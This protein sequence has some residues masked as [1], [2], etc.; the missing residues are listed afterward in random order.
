MYTFFTETLPRR[1]YAA[2]L[3]GLH[4]GRAAASADAAELRRGNSYG[5]AIVTAWQSYGVAKLREARIRARNRSAKRVPEG[6]PG[7][8]G[9]PGGCPEGIP[10][11]VP[12]GVPQMTGNIEKRQVL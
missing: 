6:V 9:G 12:K 8:P 10:G 2:S 7:D 1:N 11:G 5:A 3:L 4:F